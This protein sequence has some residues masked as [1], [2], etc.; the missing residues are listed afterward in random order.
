SARPRPALALP[1]TASIAGVAAA[2]ALAGVASV[3]I[4]WGYE[5]FLSLVVADTN[6]DLLHF[7][8]HPLSP[9]RVALEFALVMLHA[10]VIWAVVAILRLP[11]LVWRL[12]RHDPWRAAAAA[13]AIAGGA[14][15]ARGAR[16]ARAPPPLGPAGSALARAAGCAPV[17]PPPGVP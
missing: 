9:A 11:A 14:A 10:S 7:S 6:L 15:A 3:V 16:L 2:Y 4:L 17:A 8:L 13:S 5:D 1:A 12:P